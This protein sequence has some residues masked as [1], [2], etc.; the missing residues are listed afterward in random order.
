MLRKHVRVQS[1]FN[2]RCVLGRTVITKPNQHRQDP[3]RVHTRHE[4]VLSNA[5][6]NIDWLYEFS[7]D[8]EKRF[9][10]ARVRIPASTLRGCAHV[11][12][13]TR[14]CL[15]VSIEPTPSY[16]ARMGT[17]FAAQTSRWSD[18]AAP[19]L[20]LLHLETQTRQIRQSDAEPASP[21]SMQPVPKYQ[22]VRAA[23]ARALERTNCPHVVAP[24]LV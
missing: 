24:R 20:V 2:A 12:V 19:R 11:T 9:S 10:R 7:P 15:L 23:F 6:R 16:V 21:T 22:M 8:L 1:S 17:P 14:L 13:Y 3:A 18:V 4:F 5:R